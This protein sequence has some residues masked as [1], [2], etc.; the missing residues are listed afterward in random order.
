MK[1]AFIS[2]RRGPSTPY[3]RQIYD[4]LSERVGRDRVFFDI[5]TLEPGTDFLEVIERHIDQSGLMLVIIDP[6][7]STVEHP[8]GNLRLD[9]EDDPVRMEVS[10]ALERKLTVLPVLVAGAKMPKADALPEDLKPFVRRQAYEL[11]DTHWG[12]DM[13]ELVKRVASSLEIKRVKPA[14]KRGSAS[15][16]SGRGF[17]KGTIAASVLSNVWR[18]A[19]LFQAH[20]VQAIAATALVGTTAAVGAVQF[21]G[22][23]RIP[24]EERV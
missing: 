6:T 23:H 20:P 24:A 11:T 4:E 15:D 1:R 5:D 3:A 16:E 9:D 14:R 12:D 13:D 10:R 17:L 8:N 21:A 19:G 2:Y 22:P 18:V 7:W